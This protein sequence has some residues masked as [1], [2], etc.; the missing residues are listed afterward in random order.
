MYD[1]MNEDCATTDIFENYEVCSK[2]PITREIGSLA[3]SICIKLESISWEEILVTQFGKKTS[4]AIYSF[5][6][7]FF[8]AQRPF[9]TLKSGLRA[10]AQ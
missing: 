8:F 7:S 6:T 4:S 1:V 3:R 2:G 5:R 9:Y 10:Q